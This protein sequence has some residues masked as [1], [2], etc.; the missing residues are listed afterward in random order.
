MMATVVS[1][2]LIP[3]VLIFVEE[4]VMG[5]R[6]VSLAEYRVKVKFERIFGP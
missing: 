2:L 3:W 1:S 5:N 6:K 4:H